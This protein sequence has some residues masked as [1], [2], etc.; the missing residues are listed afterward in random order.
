LEISSVLLGPQQATAIG[1]VARTS[2]LGAFTAGQGYIGDGAY[3][4]R[5]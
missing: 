4:A 5:R 2:I 3:S 1:T